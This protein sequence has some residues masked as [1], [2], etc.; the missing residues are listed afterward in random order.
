MKAMLWLV[1]GF[2]AGGGILLGV[3]G[4]FGAEAGPA[5][6]VYPTMGFDGLVGSGA[7]EVTSQGWMAV[8]M[9]LVGVALMATAS[10]NAYKETGGY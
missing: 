5:S 4:G 10:R 8:G 9:F 3:L 1:G 6:Q 7:V 2:S